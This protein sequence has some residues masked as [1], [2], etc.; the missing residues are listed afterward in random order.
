[1]IT[2]SCWCPLCLVDWD[3]I[4]FSVADVQNLMHM[5]PT[6]LR[7]MGFFLYNMSLLCMLVFCILLQLSVL[8]IQLSSP[9]TGACKIKNSKITEVFFSVIADLWEGYCRFRCIWWSVPV[10]TT[11]W[12][13]FIWA[14]IHLPPM[15]YCM[16]FTFRLI[17]CFRCFTHAGSDLKFSYRFVQLQAAHPGGKVSWG[18]L[19][20][21]GSPRH[22]GCMW[23]IPSSVWWEWR[24]RWLYFCWGLPSVG[25]WNRKDNWFC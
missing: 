11:P 10:L 24:R 3:S 9:V 23:P 1:M 4:Q 25:Q 20:G 18:C 16:F 5:L 8:Q 15:P 12:P 17:A 21:S 19:L 22:P 13:W 6:Q 7:F 2:F 14:Q